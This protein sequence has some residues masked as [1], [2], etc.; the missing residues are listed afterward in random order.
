A[1]DPAGPAAPAADAWPPAAAR[2]LPVE[3]LY[4]ELA[5]EGYEY[6]PAFRGVRAAW[7]H[8]EEVLADVALPAGLAPA[9][10]SFGLHPALLDAAL[11]LTDLAADAAGGDAAGGGPRLPFAWTAYTLHATG[12]AELRVRISPAGPDGVALRLTTPD[13]RPVASVGG[14]RT[15]PVTADALAPSPGGALYRIDRVPLDGHPATP[16]PWTDHTELPGTGPVPATVVLRPGG[17]V[18]GA[19]TAWAADDRTADSR[20][21]VVTE[22]ADTDTEQAA[23]SGLVR[24]AQA[25]QPGRH[26]LLDLEGPADAA[27]LD[28]VLGTVLASGEPEVTVRD[29]VPCAPRLARLAP[30]RTTPAPAPFAPSGT[31]LVTGGTGALGGL[32]ARHLV[33]RHGVRHLLLVGRRGPDA[34]GAEELASQLTALGAEVRIAACDVTDRAALARLLADIPEEHP[35]TSV[36]HTAGILDDA[37]TGDLTPQRMAAVRAPKADAARYLHELTR[38][39]ELASFVLF[40]S[41]AALVDGAGQGNY[42]AANASL[43]ALA[44]QRRA[45]GL[46]ALSL[47]WGLWSGT[48]GMGATLDGAAARRVGRQGLAPLSPAQ[49]LALFDLAL[50]SG[51]AHLAPLRVDNAALRARPDGVPALLSGLVPVRRSPAAAVAADADRVRFDALDRVSTRL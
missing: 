36:V 43:D 49:N 7:R 39:L 18:L 13:G 21:V 4:G 38:D 42:A 51:E 25:E 10:A 17:D 37:L 1:E 12:A 24:A 5:A 19:L 30:G 11:H 35:L 46:P 34:P 2:P 9:A 44:R 26:L 14:Y 16:A 50:S 28:A 27:A 41:A 15:R 47:A 31:V 23:V 20:L 22:H 45:S 6:G 8:G 29:G 33:E 40:S 32:L 3:N 48:T